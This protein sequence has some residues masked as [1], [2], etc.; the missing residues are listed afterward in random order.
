M[1][2]QK[3]PDIDFEFF[4]ISQV[5]ELFKE[6][7]IC[8]NEEY[9]RGD[10][11]KQTQQIE[12][13][14]SIEKRYSIGVIVLYINDKGQYEILDGQQ[15]LL[16][17]HKYLNDNV[18][19]TNTEIS[20]YSE[21]DIKN[22][23]LLDAYCVYYIKLKSHDAET[24]EE[25]IVQTF[26]RLQ[27]GTPLNK[28][29]KINAY[30][31]RFKNTFRE[32]RMSR[33]LFSALG[34]EKRFRFRQLAAELLLLELESNFDKKVFP[35]LDLTSL[36]SALK[37]YEKD[38]SGK[39]VSFYNGNLDIL[40]RSLNVILTALTPREII[41]FYLLV[42]YL[43]KVKADNSNLLSELNEFAV[44]FLKNLYSF[45]MYDDM[46][47]TGMDVQLFNEYKIY[48]QEAKVQT[49]AE[50]IEKRFDMVLKEYN[51]IKPFIIKDKKRLFDE[52]QKRT[53]YFR[54]KGL[55][56][57]C[58]KPLKFEISSAHHGVAHSAGGK[59]DDLENAKL[60]HEKCHRMLEN[61]LKSE[62][63][64]RVKKSG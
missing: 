4:V 30:R 1:Q 36:I 63:R 62:K 55:C 22:K 52:D 56:A 50:S 23:T 13:I 43:R 41:S 33:E 29:E 49:T 34:K 24:K 61:K 17:I 45:S 40:Y 20:K 16:T 6:G 26:L 42:S 25:D 60:L 7:K 51:R 14:K 48:K 57:E 10:I 38:I 2:L 54:Q 21:L 28:A 37:K 47:P 44:E 9:Q 15:R 12:L 31:G 19:L 64:D 8:I 59:T 53:L 39:K 35:S 46:P 5:N 11:W 58:D 3:V 32:A 18:D 27:E